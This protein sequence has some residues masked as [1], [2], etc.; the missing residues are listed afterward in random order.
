[1][2][3]TWTISEVDTNKLT[4]MKPVSLITLSQHHNINYPYLDLFFKLSKKNPLYVSTGQQ[5]VDYCVCFCSCQTE[6]PALRGPVFVAKS[7]HL[8]PCFDSNQRSINQLHL[9]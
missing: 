5:Q 4:V 3:Q 8:H 9:S 6:Q 1:M 7:A 2:A